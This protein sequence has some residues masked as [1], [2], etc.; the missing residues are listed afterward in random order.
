MNLKITKAE[1]CDAES[2]CEALRD[3]DELEITSMGGTP[4]EA[5][6]EA[7][8]GGMIYTAKDKAGKVVCMFG[9]GDS[10]YEKGSGVVWM[11]GSPLVEK[12]KKDVI[13]LTK[14]FV[15]KITSPYK[16]VYNFIHKDNSKSIRWLEWCGFNIDKSEKHEF[17]GESFYF[18]HKEVADV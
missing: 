12:Y 7:F 4:R 6:L 5:L 9:S 18:F 16:K 10:E 2:L 17:G 14:R 1:K 11:L 13:R 3:I 8:E 15:N